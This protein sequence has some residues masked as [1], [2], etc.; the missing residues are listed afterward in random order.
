MSGSQRAPLRVLLACDRLGYDNGGLHGAGRCMIEWSR[1]LLARGVDVTPVILRAPPALQAVAEREALPFLFLQRSSFDPRTL[2]D[3]LSLVRRRGIQVLHLQAH[4]SS[5]FGR[6]AARIARR[7]AIVHVHAD[8]R[9][10]PKGYPAYVRAADRAL[11]PG[12]A[13]ALSVAEQLIPFMVEDQGFRREQIEVLR[14][15]VDLERF[16]PPTELER[17]EARAV[18]SLEPTARVVTALGRL[19]RLKGIDVLLEAW[20]AVATDGEASTLLLV[21]DGP[22]RASLERM[23]ASRGLGNVRFLG[24]QADVRPALWSSDL[25]AMPSRQEAMPMA[26]LEALACG[27]PLIGSR[28]GGIPEIVSDGDNGLLVPV[29]DAR[30]LAAAIAGLLADEPRRRS[31][32]EGALRLIEPY[33]LETFVATLEALYRELVEGRRW[34]R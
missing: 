26:A 20:A 9:L 31:L 8:Y 11:A 29:E 18:L 13:V 33:G 10:S 32:S 6:L 17:R 3:F 4:G 2:T 12:T 34:G 1:G 5:M 21:G 25:V 24:Q 22:E 14:N 27:V 28:V 30:G 16:R 19:D 15:P 7:P 23:A